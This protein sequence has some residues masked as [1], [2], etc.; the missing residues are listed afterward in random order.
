M[1]NEELATR[2]KA[3][4]RELTSEL[5]EQVRKYL[6]YRAKRFYNAN[7]ERC[8]RAGFTLD[9]LGQE[10][11]FVFLKAVQYWKPE[12]GYKFTTFLDFPF[13]NTCKQLL[14]IARKGTDPLN[15]CVSLDRP[16][17]EEDSEGTTLGDLQ[18]DETAHEFIYRVEQEAISQVIAQEVDSLAEPVCSVVKQ[19]YLEGL[20]FKRI[21]ELRGVSHQ[22]ARQLL[23]KGTRE[24]RK[25]NVLRRL[26]VEHYKQRYRQR[27]DKYYTW[28][29]EHYEAARAERN[30]ERNCTGWRGEIVSELELA[31]EISD[32]L[33]L[34]QALNRQDSTNA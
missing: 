19:Y 30:A 28:Q 1:T 9:D 6:Y 20:T 29:P 7:C 15:C 32:M 14:G 26:Y 12:S 24:L 8:A 13:K 18:A 2:I 17:K 23:E 31:N 27:R 10:C 16:C 33:R 3:G 4:E 11:Y 25:S 22:R 34:L 21:G 5:W